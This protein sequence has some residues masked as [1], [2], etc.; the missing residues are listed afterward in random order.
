MVTELL[1]QGWALAVVD[2]DEAGEHDVG[3]Q[4]GTRVT[5]GAE[6]IHFLVPERLLG[7]D[8]EGEQEEG[9]DGEE[10]KTGEQWSRH[11][12][13]DEEV[14][15]AKGLAGILP[16][17]LGWRKGREC[18]SSYRGRRPSCTV[19][20]VNRRTI[21]YSSLSLAVTDGQDCASITGSSGIHQR[22]LVKDMARRR[23]QWVARSGGGGER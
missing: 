12:I 17:R 3:V 8:G 18:M 4:A 11:G 20:D 19:V 6:G 13:Q 9:N 2:G 16:H 1:E 21:L 10:G 15:K 7:Y 5:A 23:G 22:D 14:V